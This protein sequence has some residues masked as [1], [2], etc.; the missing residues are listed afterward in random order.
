MNIGF[1]SVFIVEQL[2]IMC[3]VWLIYIAMYIRS[4]IMHTSL[5]VRLIL[6][7]SIRSSEGF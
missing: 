2:I 6:A 4:V 7:L 5:S 1:Y 3:G